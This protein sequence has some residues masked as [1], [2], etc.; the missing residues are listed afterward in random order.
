MF[1]V[2]FIFSKS[3]VL[4]DICI[5]QGELPWWLLCSIWP[6]V[7]FYSLIFIHRVTSLYLYL[8]ILIFI[9]FVGVVMLLSYFL[10]YWLLHLIE[11]KCFLNL[12]LIGL[13]FKFFLGGLNFFLLKLVNDQVNI[14]DAGLS[15]NFSKMKKKIREEQ[16]RTLGH[17]NISVSC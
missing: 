12:T 3:K 13:F 5:R 2:F 14:M 6:Y 7:S 15:P 8:R 10:W 16:T 11:L 9:F 4:R 1:H 17:T